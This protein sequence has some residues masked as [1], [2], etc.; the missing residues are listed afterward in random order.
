[1]IGTG[2]Q[3]VGARLLAAA[4]DGPG[5]DRAEA[6]AAAAAAVGPDAVGQLVDGRGE[7]RGGRWRAGQ[8]AVAAAGN[9]AESDRLAIGGGRFARQ[10]EARILQLFGRFDAVVAQPATRART[11]NRAV[12]WRV[13]SFFLFIYLL[14]TEQSTHRILSPH[15]DVMRRGID[16]QR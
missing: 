7:R 3:Q 16:Q 1:M 5:A 2:R 15:R 11:R 8:Q 13:R 14:T 9:G 10:R 12:S 6:D 4:Q